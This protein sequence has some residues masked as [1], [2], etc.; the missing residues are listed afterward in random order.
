MP[1]VLSIS[2]N[3]NGGGV[4]EGVATALMAYLRN[5]PDHHLPPQQ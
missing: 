4:L 2:T 5:A 3:G 1:E